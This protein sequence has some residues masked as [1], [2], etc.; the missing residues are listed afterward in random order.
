MSGDSSEQKT[1]PASQQK[2]RKQRREGQVPQAR[3]PA[4]YASTAI[5]IGTLLVLAPMMH[6]ALEAYL[7]GLMHSLGGPLKPVLPERLQALSTLIFRLTAPIFLVAV[8]GA[9]LLTFLFLKGIPFSAAPLKPDFSRLNPA[10]GFKRIFGM[11]S[12]I[13]VGS[14]FVVLLV[15]L[16][17]ATLVL[18][19]LIRPILAMHGCG[20]SCM[21]PIA[22]TI[23]H[24]LAWL[25]IGVCTLLV[26]LELILQRGIF[27]HEQRMT[28]TEHKR[29]VKDQ[30]GSPEIRSERRRLQREAR[31]EA[32]AQRIHAGIDRANMCF[33]THDNA[34]AIRYHPKQ[35]PLPRVAAVA[36]G[37]DAALALRH[38]VASNGFREL[39]DAAITDGCLA[40]RPG[41]PVP[42][43]VFADLAQGMSK[44]HR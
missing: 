1:R 28:E 41:M 32:E 3:K 35:V 16:G 2:L 10:S 12:L 24:R 20:L 9:V 17:A 44:L 11:R 23:A 39:Q 29:E 25:A 26:G 13:E 36:R 4:G 5:A 19:G 27:L 8:V 40:V 38:Q 42:E 43:R 33:F 21:G 37:R 18:A 31:D 7:D 30:Y 34:V 15:W 14:E 6:G 22:T